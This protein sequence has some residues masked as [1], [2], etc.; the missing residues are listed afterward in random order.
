MAAKVSV[1]LPTYN[2]ANSLVSACQSVLG[3]SFRDI[4][5]IVVDDGSKD[6]IETLVRGIGDPRLKYIRRPS[7]GGAAAAR[8]T[9]LAVAEGEF[10]AFQD[11][12]DLW[13]PNKL[14]RQMDLFARLAPDVGVVTGAKIIYGRDANFNFGSGKVAV[15]PAPESQLRLDEDQLA[16]LLTE[17]RISLQ[18]SLFKSDCL[19]AKGWFDSSAKANED[20]EFAIRLAQ[21]TKIYEDPEPVVMAFMSSDSISA[22]FRKEGIGVVRVLKKNRLAFS[23]YKMQ[24]AAIL[25]DVGRILYKAG[26][27]K[28]A[29]RFVVESVKTHPASIL[30]VAR[31]LVRKSYMRV[32]GAMR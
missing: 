30:L 28:A 4:E 7:N 14:Q 21:H 16:H 29:R 31:A 19:P 18:N 32:C 11:S 20:W 6:D 15:A 1:V 8:N 25:L 27:P 2:R 17:N 13:L 12:D 23:R 3:Q 10:I 26:K 9:G 22:N 5:L 24:Y